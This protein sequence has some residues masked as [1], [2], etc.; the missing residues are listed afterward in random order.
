MFPPASLI[1]FGGGLFTCRAARRF[2]V[3]HG[4]KG[5][6]SF[7]LIGA[8]WPADERT[9]FWHLPISFLDPRDDTEA[10]F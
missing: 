1:T 9:I 7:G 3:W 2:P 4:C 6:L 5:Q 10:S 8:D